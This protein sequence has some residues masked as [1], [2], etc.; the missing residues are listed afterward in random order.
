M[1]ELRAFLGRLLSFPQNCLETCCPQ[2]LL[3]ELREEDQ[4]VLSMRCELRTEQDGNH[5]HAY[6]L[7]E[8][9]VRP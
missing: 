8:G 4:Q 1:S 2:A 5:S 3:A 6:P 9:Q 7:A